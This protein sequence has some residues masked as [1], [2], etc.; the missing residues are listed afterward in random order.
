MALLGAAALL[1]AAAGALLGPDAAGLLAAGAAVLGLCALLGVWVRHRAKEK[2]SSPAGRR[3]FA[4]LG[5][6]AAALFTVSGV[7]AV[8]RWQWATAV[9]SALPLDGKTV[10]ISG[11]V[12]DVPEEE[13]HR[14]YYR[15]RVERVT[16]ADGE[17]RETAFTARLSLVQ[18]LVCR[19]FDRVRGKVTFTAYDRDGSLFS[20]ANNALADGVAIRGYFTGG[21]RP[22]VLSG[23]DNPPGKIWALLRA[24]VGRGL[25]R[26][27]PR[28]EAGLIRAMLLGQRDRVTQEDEANFRGVGASH[29]LVIS[30][31]HLTALAGLLMLLT[32][33]LPGSA[34][35]RDGLVLAGVWG[36]L[37]LIGLPASAVRAGIM[38]TLTVL[39][40]GVTRGAGGVNALG[41]AVWALCLA[42]PFL[43]GDV[44]FYLSAAGT[45]ALVTVAEPLTGWLLRP[46]A[47]RPRL[48]RALRFP[49]G[50]VG[51]TVAVQGM[52]LPLQIMCF[53][54]TSLLAPLAGLVLALPCALLLVLAVLGAAAGL[55]PL[56]AGVQEGLVWAAGLLARGVEALAEGL[57]R[58]PGA[59]LDLTSPT[60]LWT[61]GVCLVLAALALARRRSPRVR[62][63]TAALMALVAAVSIGAAAWTRDRDVLLAVAPDSTCV[64]AFRGDRAVVLSLGGYNT[65]A[66]RELLTRRN[67]SRVELLCLPVGDQDAREA[68]GQILERWPVEQAVL[69]AGSYGGRDLTRRL[70]A[71]R[72]VFPGEG[73]SLAVLGDVP[74]R[75]TPELDRLELEVFGNTV[76]LELGES[77]GGDC[78]LLLTACEA[79]RVNCS[80]SVLLDRGIIEDENNTLPGESCILPEDTLWVRLHPDG[81][82]ELQGERYG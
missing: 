47:R 33:L 4:L 29:L 62:R 46:F 24:Q 30:G 57:A 31:L 61:L 52:T 59:F 58:W 15:V 9:A 80:L 35:L 34:R 2:L 71:E 55:I 14:V 51:M 77:R 64:A 7:L 20:R 48:K 39:S 69:P 81:T 50:V 42:R 8:Y 40:R 66:A 6:G 43:G 75:L 37:L 68:A 23:L 11:T 78:S 82:A 22:Q 10:S 5:W 53:G 73:E 67:V 74:L 18:P 21:T 19:P 17:T 12:L 32:R 54:G 63:T 25:D 3:A 28:R 13:Y 26:R 72:L 70:G 76:V 16:M 1:A 38:F 44:G 65:G 56:L 36:Y 49:L 45:F 27:L 79:S 60:V 41:A